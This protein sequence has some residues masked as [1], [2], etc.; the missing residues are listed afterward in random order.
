MMWTCEKLTGEVGA[1][2][3]G[4]DLNTLSSADFDGLQTA[5]IEYGVVTLPRQKLTP[6]GHIAL[7]ERFGEIDI[8][9]FFTPVP[10]YPMIAEVRTKPDSRQ[11]IG[12]TWHTDHSY[13][14]APAMCSILAA[15]NLP[16][17]GGDTIFASMTAACAALSPGLRTSLE[18]LRGVH[19]DG[20][21]K[22][23]AL[24][25]NQSEE[26]YKEPVSHPVLIRHPVSGAQAV[27]VNGDFTT[28]FEAWSVEES[29]PLLEYLYRFVTQPEFTCRVVWEDD[30]VAI[31]DNRLVQHF[32]V[33][34]YSGHARVMHRITVK[35]VPLG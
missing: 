17:Y 1:R 14:R 8:N 19:S 24:D 18:Q 35:G 22:N 23:S 13:D 12:G 28:Q 11:V 2:L 34:D 27:Y 15:R 10:E 16:P 5:L 26:A 31:W 3:T 29:A 9:R 21:F 25:M 7:A 4:H 32:A 30:M 6:Q 33:A 20:S